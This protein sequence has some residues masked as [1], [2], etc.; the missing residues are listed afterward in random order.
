VEFASLVPLERRG[1]RPPLFCVHGGGGHCYCYRDLARRLG[2]DQ[3]FWGLQGRHVDGRLPRQTSV[4]EMAEHYLEEIKQVAPKGPYYLAGASF[5]GKVAFEMAQ[6]LRRRGEVVALLA[7]FDTWG[8][9][10]PTFRVSR[11]LRTAGWLYRRVEHH[12]GSVM[13]L[14]AADRRRY[15]RA[16]GAKTWQEIGDLIRL[17]LATLKGACAVDNET[18]MDEGFIALASRRY[19]PSFYPGKIILFRSKQQP[20]GI[21]HDRTLGWAGLAGDLEIYDVVGLHAAVVAEPRVKYLVER[22]RPCLERAQ[23]AYSSHP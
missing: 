17:R 5:G 14:D 10:Y 3:P 12:I 21:V 23:A 19:R 4:E 7:M 18:D 8:P 22:F 13:L 15:L 20:L 16:K 11:L 2:S 1:T 6:I 9:D